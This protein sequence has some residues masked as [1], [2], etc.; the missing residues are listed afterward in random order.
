MITE[1]CV[2]MH[3]SPCTCPDFAS[4]QINN[5]SSSNILSKAFH[6][7]WLGRINLFILNL[8]PIHLMKKQRKLTHMNLLPCYLWL[9]RLIPRTTKFP[10]SL[11]RKLFHNISL[12]F[13]L[14]FFLPNSFWDERNKAAHCTIVYE[15]LKFI[16]WYNNVFRLVFFIS[17]LTILS[18]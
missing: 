15:N 4:T 10:L 12:S 18:T 14:K 3:F 6:L 13:V 2:T 8:P 5:F 11:Y 1:Y 7:C 16:Y 17:L 9:C